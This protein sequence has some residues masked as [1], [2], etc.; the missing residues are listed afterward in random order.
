[1]WKYKVNNKQFASIFANC[2][3]LTESSYNVNMNFIINTGLHYGRISKPTKDKYHND[4]LYSDRH[5]FSIKPLSFIESRK[6]Y[7]EGTTMCI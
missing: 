5:V 3:S 1:M 4:A 7:L 6:M 2:K